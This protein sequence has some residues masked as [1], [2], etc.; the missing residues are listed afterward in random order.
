MGNFN[1]PVDIGNRGLQHC[2]VSAITSFD[3]DK[4]GA[5]AVA[6]CYD[7][8]RR[9]ELRRNVWR[10]AVRRAILYPVNTPLGNA[11]IGGTVQPT[12][13]LVPS[14]WSATRQYGVGHMVTYNNV[15]WVNQATTSVNDTPG[16]AKN[17]DAYFGSMCVQPWLAQG[18]VV[19]TPN[20]TVTI[21][22]PNYNAGDL[23]YVG[24]QAYV[25]LENNNAASPTAASAWAATS[26]YQLGSVVVDSD[27]FYWRSN[28][29]NNLVAQ[30]G[31]YGFWNSSPTY[32]I[33]ALVIGSDRVLYKALVSNT[34]FNPASGA[35]PT[36]W[37]VVG[38]PGSYPKW[39][40]GQTY[41]KDDFT[42]GD[43]G[44]LYQSV[45]GSNIGNQPVGS[46]FN[47]NTPATNWWVKTTVQVPWISNFQTSA[48]NQG[49][50]ALDATLDNLNIQYPAGAGPAYQ[51]QTRNV[52]VL[53]AGFLRMAPEDPK[54]GSVSFLG[55][56]TGIQ[57]RDWNLDGNFIISREAY[58]IMVR[59]VADITQVWKM[60][61]MFCEGLGC[62]I[63]E[64]ICEELTQKAS[65]T[66][67]IQGKYK[68]FMTEARTVNGI[69][70][71]PTEP[72]EDDY[73]TTRI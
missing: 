5:A 53:P 43:D 24:E 16:T 39:N 8:L 3:D 6:N 12:L 19:T 58:P 20:G 65:L 32:G 59:F 26:Y 71:Q 66:S 52:F 31:V 9:A 14:A 61:D 11:P 27:G 34:N 48:S 50:L 2:G 37:S 45:Q 40:A 21:P 7:H 35:N 25:S 54:Q 57:Y 46:T 69:E 63:G 67:N 55:A 13:L 23:V 36:K 72:Y 47:P 42:S 10:F 60:D 17:W 30:P 18:T 73:I 62:R 1:A 38:A 15:T 44:Y 49:W 28:I 41:A 22:A 29:N 68:Q 33:G 4:K 51:M 64:E 70:E 56:P